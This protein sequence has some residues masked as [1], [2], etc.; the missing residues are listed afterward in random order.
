M[1]KFR[2]VSFRSFAA[3]AAVQYNNTRSKLILIFS[4]SVG[5]GRKSSLKGCFG[6]K[7]KT[8]IYCKITPNAAWIQDTVLRMLHLHPNLWHVPF[9]TQISPK[10][11]L[12]RTLMNN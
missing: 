4:R 10:G 12:A 7:T 1:S 2:F 11:A 9:A 6:H 8:A 3:A 5:W